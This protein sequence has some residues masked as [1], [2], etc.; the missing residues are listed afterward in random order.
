MAGRKADGQSRMGPE[1]TRVDLSAE[2]DLRLKSVS[3]DLRSICRVNKKTYSAFCF[4]ATSL[5]NNMSSLLHIS[6]QV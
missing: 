2:E 1:M 6:I 3:E 5:R 4:I